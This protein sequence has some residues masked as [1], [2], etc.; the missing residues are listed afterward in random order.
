MAKNKWRKMK[1]DYGLFDW[2]VT[3]TGVCIKDPDGKKHLVS[4]YDLTGIHEYAYSNDRWE[5]SASVR[6]RH[7][8][9]WIEKKQWQ[10]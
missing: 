1:T 5:Q 7:I 10:K 2:V 4:F 9:D 8:K 3:K 6:P